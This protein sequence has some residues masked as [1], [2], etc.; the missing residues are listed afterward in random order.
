MSFL[1]NKFMPSNFDVIIDSTKAI[2]TLGFKPL[3]I[4]DGLKKYVKE[5]K[6]E[7]L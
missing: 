2:K 6:N 5:I 1:F 4:Q 3:S 7:N